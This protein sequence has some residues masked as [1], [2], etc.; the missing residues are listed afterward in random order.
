VSITAPAPSPTP[1]RASRRRTPKPTAG[2]APPV[3]VEVLRERVVESRHRGHVVQVDAVGD[4]ARAIG[5]PTVVVAMRSTIKPF[6]VVALIESGAADELT[7]SR[8]ELA[9][10]AGSHAGEDK[11]V[12][13]LQAVFR[14][15]NLSQSLLACGAEGMPLDAR[16]ASR[17]A[18]DNE[19]AGPMRH[20]CAGYHLAHI[21]LSRHAGWT[22]DDYADTAHKSQLA[23]RDTVARLLGRKAT[24]LVP[25]PDDCG[26]LTYAVPLVDVA[27]AFLLLAD[28]EATAND[29]PRSRSA[30]AL[31]RIRDAMMAAPD[32]IGGTYE[33]LDTDLMRRRSGQVVAKGGAEG[34][35]GVGLVPAPRSRGPVP[36]GLAVSIED[37]DA[38][39]RA[40]RAVTVEALAQLG[41]LDELDLRA[42]AFF[43]RPVRHGPDGSAIATSVPRFE[44]APMT[45]LT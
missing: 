17:L 13:T 5:D 8:E 7:L 41:T 29:E 33:V 20:M 14:R 6:G 24:D 35:R 39:A 44:L 31:L 1:L 18:R 34:L 42:L 45:E 3:L 16:T 15:A 12:R 25:V 38:A 37:G 9:I 11:H 43:H 30:P 4:I 23:V 22:M 2:L 32:M 36:G 26:L 21:L 10:M 28:P 27:R 19:A 40:S